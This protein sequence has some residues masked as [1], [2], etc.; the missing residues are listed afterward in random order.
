[1]T[2]GN[3]RMQNEKMGEMSAVSKMGNGMSGRENM[4]RWKYLFPSLQPE[5]E[6]VSGHLV[7]MAIN[8]AGRFDMR[9]DLRVRQRGAATGSCE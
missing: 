4:S 3:S 1:M 8:V 7:V 9:C 2:R 5:P 6:V